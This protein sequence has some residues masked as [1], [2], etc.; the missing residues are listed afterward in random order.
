LTNGVATEA[1]APIGVGRWELIGLAG[2]A[3]LVVAV[4]A[5]P[6]Y[7]LADNPTR[8]AGGG[9]VCGAGQFSCT[10]FE[11][12]PVLRWLLLAAALS[13]VALLYVVS[14]GGRVKYPPGEITM[15]AGAAATLLIFYNGVMDR[16]GT[17][18]D[19]AGIGLDIG[20]FLALLGAAAIA[21]AGI[22]RSA[23][24]TGG[25]ERKPPGVF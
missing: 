18:I 13:P 22:A 14:R 20:Y 4:L 25:E 11:T 9:F 16:P 1:R 10:G 21:A 3:V 6:W 2:A 7:S 5:L 19:E 23:S 8:Q 24:A 15:I 12:F 17:G